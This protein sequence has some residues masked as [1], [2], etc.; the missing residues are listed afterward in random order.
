[1]SR[2]ARTAVVAGVV[3]ILCAIVLAFG[4][5]AAV[6][7]DVSAPLFMIMLASTLVGLVAGMLAIRRRDDR[8][9]A[10]AGIVLTLPALIVI[11]IVALVLVALVSGEFQPS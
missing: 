8:R 10:V 4:Q 9:L 11:G 7:S 2:A 6:R 1:M 5:A 3:S